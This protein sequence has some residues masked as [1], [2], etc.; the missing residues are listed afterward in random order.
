MTI[1]NVIFLPVSYVLMLISLCSLSLVSTTVVSTP[2]LSDNTIV[3]AVPSPPYRVKKI[4]MLI[5]ARTVATVDGV[6]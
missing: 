4:E 5:P 2:A 1:N 6:V 3:Y